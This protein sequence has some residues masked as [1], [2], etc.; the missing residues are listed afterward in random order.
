MCGR[1]G[2]GGGGEVKR[3]RGKQSCACAVWVLG[4][5]NPQLPSCVLP[6]HSSHPPPPPTHLHGWGVGGVYV[7]G[8]A[9]AAPAR[10]LRFGACKQGASDAA[11]A[12]CWGDS[13]VGEISNA[14]PSH[15]PVSKRGVGGGGGGGARGGGRDAGVGGR[16]GKVGRGEQGRTRTSPRPLHART[17]PHPPDEPVGHE[18]ALERQ[19]VSHRVHHHSTIHPRRSS[20]SIGGGS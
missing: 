4:V 18:L 9:A 8:H 7:Q 2:G 14:I 12:R 17:H 6:T 16:R 3:G 13:Q 19:K 10:R 15:L 20:S 1:W 11:A 5:V